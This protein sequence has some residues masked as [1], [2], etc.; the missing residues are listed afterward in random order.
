MYTY[1]CILHAMHASML[2]MTRARLHTTQLHSPGINHSCCIASSH[3]T[4]KGIPRDS[5]LTFFRLPA[6]HNIT[7][8]VNVMSQPNSLASNYCATRCPAPN[9]DT[10]PQRPGKRTSMMQSG[11]ERIFQ[12]HGHKLTQTN[13]NRQEIL[14]PQTANRAC[15]YT[16][17]RN[18]ERNP[19]NCL[20][21][22]TYLLPKR[23]RHDSDKGSPPCPQ[24]SL[25][26]ARYPAKITLTLTRK[27]IK[28]R[29]T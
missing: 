15:P 19:T 4:A 11:E 24:G 7:A 16:P 17:T 1:R 2:A 28:S 27:E 9:Q 25:N 12:T 8:S 21:D 10:G 20:N 18:T 29:Y 26:R 3:S 6:K 14:E 13:T 22:N 23:W 5:I